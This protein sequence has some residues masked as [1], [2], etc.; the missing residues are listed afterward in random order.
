MLRALPRD[1]DLGRQLFPLIEQGKLAPSH[2]VVELVADRLTQPDV[3]DGVV[4]D[5]SPRTQLEK[6]MLEQIGFPITYL[7]LAVDRDVAVERLLKRAEI[8]NRADDS[9]DVI[10]NR[11]RVHDAEIEPMIERLRASGEMVTVQVSEAEPNVNAARAKKA[12]AAT[13]LAEAY[14]ESEHPRDE[15]GRWIE[16]P[17]F[18]RSIIPDAHIVGGAV[19]DKLL[20]KVPKDYDF[21]AP[22]YDHETLVE[23]LAP[24]GCGRGVDRGR[25][26]GRR[27]LLPERPGRSR[28]HRRASR[29]RRRARSGAR[30]GPSRL[31]DRGRRHGAARAGHGAARLHG[32]RH[33]GSA[34]RLA[35]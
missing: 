29:S 10:A 19:R 25:A 21:L 18:I 1:S 7:E 15:R 27:A 35:G 28:R 20:G 26:Q 6:E 3:R 24:H 11:F 22:G 17:D 8:E 5:G 16:V 33:R 30:Q 34:G 14:I 9:P 31:R 32:Q 4:L 23:K 13:K 2:L 12:L